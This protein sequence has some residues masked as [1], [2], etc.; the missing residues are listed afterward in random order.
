MRITG[1]SELLSGTLIL[2]ILLVFLS[3]CIS[4]CPKFLLESCILTFYFFVSSVVHISRAF[5]E[6]QLLYAS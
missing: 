3:Y 6:F 4:C 2:I 5:L 1:L